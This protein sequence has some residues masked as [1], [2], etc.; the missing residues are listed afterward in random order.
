VTVLL[1]ALDPLSFILGLLLGYLCCRWDTPLPIR[2]RRRS[3]LS[4]RRL[5]RHYPHLQAHC[6]SLRLPIG[7]VRTVGLAN[8]S[9][10]M[11]GCSTVPGRNLIYHCWL[12]DRGLM[13]WLIQ[14]GFS[15][16][17][18]CIISTYNPG[19]AKFAVICIIPDYS[20]L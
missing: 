17:C 6:S 19:F 11:S 18:A 13:D 8:Q 15:G 3:S 20:Y 16:G 9:H 7:R 10:V 1:L 5:L 2:P 4:A 12:M 14:T